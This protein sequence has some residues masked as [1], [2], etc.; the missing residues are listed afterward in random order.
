MV[1]GGVDA[2]ADGGDAPGEVDEGRDSAATGPG[3]PPVQRLLA[4]L[5]L[6][7][8]DEPQVFFEQVGTVQP[9]VGLGDPVQLGPLVGELVGVLL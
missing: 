2:G 9:R 7:L 6:D 8:E 5:A 3:Q 4:G 1:E